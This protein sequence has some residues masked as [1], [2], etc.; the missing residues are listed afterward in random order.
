MIATFLSDYHSQP[1]THLIG[2]CVFILCSWN[3][4]VKYFWKFGDSVSVQAI[5]A[6]WQHPLP[7]AQAVQG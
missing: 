3:R 6:K 7:K 5:A 4:S 2:C 1:Y